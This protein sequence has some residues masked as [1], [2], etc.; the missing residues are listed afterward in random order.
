M[1]WLDGVTDAMDEFEQALRVG[2]GQ[3]SLAW[4]SPWD[5]KETD[6]TEPLN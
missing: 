4:C 5:H 6:M 1:K 2:S 3:G